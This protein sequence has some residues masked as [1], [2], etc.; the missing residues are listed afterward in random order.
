M[1]A[2]VLGPFHRAAEQRRGG[3]HRDFLGID[4]KF[5]PEAAADIGRRHAQPAFVEIDIV[6]DGGAQIVRLL[7]RRP[8]RGFAIRDLGEDAAALHRMAGAAMHPQILANDMRRLGEGR[9]DV[10]IRDLVGNDRVR[11]QLAAH[12]RRALDPAIGRRRQHIVIDRDQRGSVFGKI[13][14]LGD[15][16]GDRLADEGDFAVSQRKRPALVKLGAGIRRPHHAPLPER[17]REIVEREH[18]DHARLCAGRSGIDA[19]DQCMRMR[20]AHEGGDQRAGRGNVVD[21]TALAGQK[22]LVFQAQDARSDQFIH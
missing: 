10:P 19:A 15:D 21:E 7:G 12:R 1:L 22:R 5:R 14:I 20:T 3:D 18:R 16:D 6:G 4:A 2:A 13:A 9:V 11:G 17:R 8:D